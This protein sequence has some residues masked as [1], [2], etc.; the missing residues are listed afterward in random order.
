MKL[1]FFE[2]RFKAK[3]IETD[4]YLEQCLAYINFNPLKH[5]I[6]ENIS[7]YKWTSYHQLDSNKINKYKDLILS[8]LE[9]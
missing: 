7:D 3:Y 2:W 6:V 8:E 5:N 1:P 9:F 4:E